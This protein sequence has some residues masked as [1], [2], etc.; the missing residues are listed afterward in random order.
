MTR[1]LKR[2]AA[3]TLALVMTMGCLT[4]CGKDEVKTD[5][6]VASGAAVTDTAVE[7]EADIE[8]TAVDI[9]TPEGYHL[10]WNDEFDGDKLNE[11]DWNRE[12]HPIGWVNN[13]LQEYL[14]V[15]DYAYV[16]DGEL[17]IQPKKE[18]LENGN[19]IYRSGRINTQNKHDIKY[20]RIEAKI[21]VPEGKGFLPAFWM[22]P[23]DEDFYGIWP[24]CGEIDIME[25]L[26]DQINTNYGTLH[27]GEPHKQN[28]GSIQLPDGDFA[29]EYHT[30]AIEWE[31]GVIKWFMDD[32]QYY[33]TSDWFT[34]VDGE[35][36]K[37]YPAP[38]NQPFHVILN[39]AIGG[40]W[41]GN[42]DET[43]IFDERAAMYVDYVRMF[44]KDSYDE[45]VQKPVKVS[46]FKEPDTSGNFITNGDFKED[47]NL[48]DDESWKFLLFKGGEGEAKIENG[49]IVISMTKTGSE[50]YGVQL[51]QPGMPMKK[52]TSYKLSFEAYAED[53]RTMKT[54]VTAPNVDWIRYFPDTEVKLG[55]KWKKYK[56]NFDMT[57]EDDDS[58]RV[59][60]NMGKV[61]STATIHIR[62]VR[63]EEA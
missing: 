5:A 37:P 58:G 49:E 6:G 60:F 61:D 3:G 32:Q 12:K 40:D 63:L 48:N 21:K 16:K 57:E 44:Q 24:K 31:P 1:G 25:V 52:G 14:P 45:N 2:T 9:P 34:A 47:E 54:A 55:K 27:Y 18:T 15:E 22:M 23:Q 53:K 35:E 8:T 42:P 43:T 7:T 62:N 4:G 10:V 17:I 56:F 20:G 39:V 29:H 30:F 28:Q 41:P 51:V 38:F 50:D 11:E 19:T 13:E 36:E 46:K 26:G 33:E 59:E